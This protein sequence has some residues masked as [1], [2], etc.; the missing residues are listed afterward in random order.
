MLQNDRVNK[1]KPTPIQIR[2]NA[3][4]AGLLGGLC[5]CIYSLLHGGFDCLCKI[6]GKHL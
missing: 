3:I 4:F 1:R 5:L 6:T 2:V